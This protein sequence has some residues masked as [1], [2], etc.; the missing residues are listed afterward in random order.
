MT[1]ARPLSFE[2]AISE[3]PVVDVEIVVPA[4]SEAEGLEASVRSLPAFLQKQ[5]PLTWTVTVADNA[6]IDQTWGVDCRL[7]G[8]LTGVRAVHFDQKGRGRA[9]RSVWSKSPARV[10][11]YK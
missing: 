7:A 11:A 6:S 9:L 8:E 2:G 10:G 4:Y 3:R 5:F 1:D